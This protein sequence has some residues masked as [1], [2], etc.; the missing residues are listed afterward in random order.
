M[1]EN[2]RAAVVKQMNL[3]EM[4][5]TARYIFSGTCISVDRRY[6]DVADREGIFYTFSVSRF[7]KGEESSEFIFKMSSVASD[8][9]QVPTFKP[10]EEVVLFLYGKST[11][12]FTSPVGL[13]LGKFS[14][15]RSPSGSKVIVNAHNNTDLFKDMNRTKY[16]ARF[17]ASHATEIS[18]LMGQKSGAINY[19]LFL[20]LLEEMV[21]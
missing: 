14:V 11:Q 18:K 5:T 9:R 3:D 2:C 8:L 17:P 7:I 19:D 10:G 20:E 13:G 21:H 15:L 1:G 4:T 6:D 16:S 12:G